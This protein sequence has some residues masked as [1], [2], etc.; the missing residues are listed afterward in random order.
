MSYY[1]KLDDI[2]SVQL[3]HTS[4]CNLA[5]PQCARTPSSS[6]YRLLPEKKDL[7]VQDYEIIFDPFIKRASSI[8][9]VHVGNFGDVIA[10]PTFDSVT[11]WCVDH[12]LTNQNIHTNGSLRTPDWWADLARKLPQAQV[13]FSIDGLNDTNHLYRIGSDYEKILENARAF[14]DAGGKANWNFLIFEHNYHQVEEAKK[15]AKKMGFF[16]FREKQT[17]RFAIHNKTKE[18]VVKPDKRKKVFTKEH[19]IKDIHN[20][21]SRKKLDELKEK[22]GD[23]ETYFKKTKITCKSLENNKNLVYVDFDM[24]VWPCCWMGT[25][26]YVYKFGNDNTV[27]KFYQEHGWDF[28][29]LKEHTWQEIMDGEFYSSYLVNS[30][31]DPEKRFNPCGKICGEEFSLSSGGGI[32][33]RPEVLNKDK[34]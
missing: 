27:P 19:E 12:N 2:R 9:I 24:R 33:Y 1:L 3:D 25:E 31:D 20:N 26:G 10:S 11:D 14:I 22:Y 7:T 18:T 23:L 16:E 34:E 6:N 17:S 8:K 13:V 5:C 29:S 21:T 28:N 15:I 30:W 4:R 32:N